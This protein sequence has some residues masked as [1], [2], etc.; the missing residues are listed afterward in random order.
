MTKAKNADTKACLVK[1][2]LNELLSPSSADDPL[3]DD[4]TNEDNLTESKK[5]MAH[6]SD[7]LAKCIAVSKY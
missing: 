5:N 2:G 1:A 3:D 4:M 7:S 6:I